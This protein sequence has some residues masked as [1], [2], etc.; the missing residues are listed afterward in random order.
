MGASARPASFCRD[1]NCI[2]VVYYGRFIGRGKFALSRAKL[3]L[4]YGNSAPQ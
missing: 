1:N 3:V 4:K 2:S